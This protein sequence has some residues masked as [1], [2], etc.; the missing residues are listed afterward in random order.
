MSAEADLSADT[1]LDICR[2]LEAAHDI[3]GWHWRD[4]T[5]W[6]ET[7]LGAILVQ[8]TAWTNV[9]KALA[10]LRDAGAFSLPAIAALAEADLADLVR[11]AGTPVQK[12]RRLKHFAALVERCGGPERFLSL[13]LEELR[14]VLLATHGI[15]PETADAIA[16]YAARRPVFVI[17]AYTVR[18][19][20]RLGLGP[21]GGRYETWQR[22]FEERLPRDGDLYR[23]Y[24]GLIVLHCKST[25]RV[26][27]RCP[28][29]CLLDA[30]PTGHSTVG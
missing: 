27:P 30:C 2:R 28:D 15:G 17:D 20:R 22:W 12:A 7:C 18:L 11:P 24:H 4:D 26:R 10:R 19:F 3:T 16:L 25:C 6:L 21:E 14:A 8:H 13:P 23:R 5:G 9:D 29:C 1:L